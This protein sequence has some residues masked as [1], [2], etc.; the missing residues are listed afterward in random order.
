[1]FNPHLEKMLLDEQNLVSEEIFKK[2]GENQEIQDMDE[3]ES[4]DLD[5]V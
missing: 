3:K 1:M 5:L 2:E 4:L